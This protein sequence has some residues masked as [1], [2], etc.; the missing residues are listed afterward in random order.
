MNQDEKEAIETGLTVLFTKANSKCYYQALVISLLFFTYATSDF[1]KLSLPTLQHPPYV[2]DYRDNKSKVLS[3]DL[4]NELGRPLEIDRSKEISSLV[5]DLKI[6]CSRTK[7]SLLGV[8]IAIG[9]LLGGLF[10]LFFGDLIGRK[11]SIFVFVP[12]HCLLIL[13]LK[14]VC[15]KY[16]YVIAIFIITETCSHIINIAIMIYVSDLVLPQNSPICVGLILLCRPFAGLIYSLIFYFTEKIGWTASIYYIFAFSVLIYIILLC[17]LMEAPLYF[18]NNKNMAKFKTNIGKIAFFNNVDIPDECFD[19]IKDIENK[20]NNISY[21][22][23]SVENDNM[24]ST[25]LLINKGESINDSPSMELLE[26]K[27]YGTVIL[28]KLYDLSPLVLFEYTSQLKPLLLHTFLWCVTLLLYNG[29]NLRSKELNLQNGANFHIFQVISFAIDLVGHF[30]VIGLITYTSIGIEST[31]ISFQLISVITVMTSLLIGN[32]NDESTHH[33]LEL[34]KKTFFVYVCKFCWNNFLL[35]LNIITI[36]CFNSMIK[37][38]GLSWCIAIGN[39]FG[40]I[41]PIFVE[42]LSFESE[43]CYYILFI[44]FSMIFSFTLPSQIGE[45]KIFEIPEKVRVHDIK[46]KLKNFDEKFNS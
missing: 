18:F 4:C 9:G 40:M 45:I 11:H 38:K 12:I 34:L 33:S 15:T 8:A 2:I 10:S 24:K 43:L 21:K 7:V 16:S 39:I 36:E 23:T 5:I 32:K 37:L 17:V 1:I 31:L 35:I 42:K 3:Y 29:I 30:F 20:K 13:L 25:D 44:F 6:Y 14:F 22:D 27:S 28:E 46:L 41:S 26:N 19:F